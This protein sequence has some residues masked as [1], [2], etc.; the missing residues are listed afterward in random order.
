MRLRGI[1]G[2]VLTSLG[3][4]GSLAKS[5]KNI[6]K[7]RWRRAVYSGSTWG[8]GNMGRRLYMHRCVGVSL[9]RGLWVFVS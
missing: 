6:I 8:W 5:F 4:F 3:C 2:G 9:G 1:R 7:Q